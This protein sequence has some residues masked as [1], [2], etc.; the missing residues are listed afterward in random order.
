MALP[1]KLKG[2]LSLELHEVH[3]KNS[4]ARRTCNGIID[5]DLD[6]HCQSGGMHLQSVK[7]FC[8]A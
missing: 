8:G 3:A 6:L 7:G 5:L 2:L 4:H 1:L